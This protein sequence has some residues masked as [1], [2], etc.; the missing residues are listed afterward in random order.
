MLVF[1][2]ESFRTSSKYGGI[3]LGVMCGIAI[4]ERDVAR[5][6]R[7]VYL[8]KVKHLGKEYASEREIKGKE[9]FKAFAFKLEDKG[10][11]S[12]NLALASDLIDYIVARGLK[13]FG[14][15][16]FERGIQKFEIENVA[17]LDKTFE[18]IFER[19]EMFIKIRH[20]DDMAIIIFDD[21]NYETNKTNSEAIT[22]FFQRSARGLSMDSI[23][24]TPMFAISQA[25]NVGLQL[26]DFVTTIVGLRFSSHER[27]QPY[28]EKLRKA[29]FYR[30]NQAGMKISSL[31][32]LRN[33]DVPDVAAPEPEAVAT[34]QDAPRAAA[35]ALEASMKAE[36]KDA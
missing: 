7:D 34:D 11:K 10:H 3:S 36:T 20:P 28:F 27:I 6:A 16:C 8:L 19:V 25:Q 14:C 4:P 5:I 9:L 35:L 1:F 30:K 32:V 33:A 15:V 23:V 2:D 21:R 12:R 18:Y 31:K 22:K 26:A 17:Q 29:F 13:V 24:A